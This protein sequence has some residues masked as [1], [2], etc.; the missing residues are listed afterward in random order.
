MA[1]KKTMMIYLISIIRAMKMK[2]MGV[3][4][5]VLSIFSKKRFRVSKK[6]LRAHSK[7]KK[8]EG[9]NLSLQDEELHLS[10]LMNVKMEKISHH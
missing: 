3:A 1:V 2:K 5:R 4:G 7:T 8:S 9:L 6:H 10:V